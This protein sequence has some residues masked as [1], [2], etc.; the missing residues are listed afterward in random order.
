MLPE[1]PVQ[2][3]ENGKKVRQ[4]S[5]IIMRRPKYAFSSVVFLGFGAFSTARTLFGKGWSPSASILYPRKMTCEAMNRHLLTFKRRPVS[6]MRFRTSSSAARWDFIWSSDDNIV[7]VDDN[8]W[9]MFQRRFSSL[10]EIFLTLKICH[11]LGD[12]S[13]RDPCGY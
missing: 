8:S 12:Y 4:K 9:D 5:A 13:E 6:S 11:G 1:Q 3:G 7:N 2:W 10:F